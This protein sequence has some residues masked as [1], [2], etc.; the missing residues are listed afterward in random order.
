MLGVAALAVLAALILSHA[1]FALYYLFSPS[2]SDHIEPNTAV[3]AWLWASG[4]QIYHPIDSAERYA[5]L[6]GPLAYVATG[7]VY[8]LLGTSTLTAKLLGV[9]CLFITMG[10]TAL[11][12]RRRFPAV[13]YPVLVALGY[14]SMLALFFKNFSFWS[15][16]DSIMLMASAVGL[17]S[18][19]IG[20]RQRPPRVAR[21]GNVRGGRG[22]GGR[23]EDN[24]R[25]LFPAL[26]W[27]VYAA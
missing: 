10:A 9:V 27:L 24:R 20:S 16:P 13:V 1:G 7:L 25:A 6:Y 4:G 2:F 15:K 23:R 8:K 14:F 17:L 26:R 21:V 11:A 19:L 18:C 5:F 3:V 12:V 22:I